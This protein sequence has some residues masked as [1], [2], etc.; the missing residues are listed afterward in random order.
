MSTFTRLHTPDDAWLARAESE[1]P[2]QPD[3]PIVDPQLHL[4]DVLGQRYFIEEYAKDIAA[5]G[6]RVE[7]SVYVECFMAYRAQGPERMK[8]VGE[9]EFAVG[10]AALGASGRYT[11]S[12]V[13]EGIVAYADV[14]LGE[15]VREVIDAHLAAGGGRLRGIRQRAKWDPDPAVRGKYHAAG[16]GLYRDAVFGR[17]L[18]I[19]TQKGLA[20][21]ASVFHPQ[22][23]DVTAMARAHPDA[24]IVL[25]HSGS[26]IGHSSYAGK[27]D[28]TH[29]DWLVSMKELASCPNV[30]VKMGG[31]LMWLGNFDFTQADKPPTSQHMA[32]LWRPFIEPCIELFGAR[33][34]ML[35][36]NFPVDKA[37]L[38]YGTLWNAFKRITAGCSDDEQRALFAGTARRVYRLSEP[39]STV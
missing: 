35:S 9:T 37:G 34:C 8:Y 6:H 1:D 28:Q 14:S 11:T 26:P 2:L 32:G 31:L 10:Q 4:W 25:A 23:P 29:A 27:L 24:S 19:L 36:S 16:P 18:G 20:F 38:S 5:S 15:S 33:R 21:E 17:G 13:A 12:R 3:L 39:P 30:S 7:A 22:I